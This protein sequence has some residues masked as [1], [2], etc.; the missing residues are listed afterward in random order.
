MA[1]YEY[2]NIPKSCEVGNTIFKKLFYEHADL[3]ISDKNLFIDNINKITWLYCLKPDNINVLPYKDDSRDYPEIEVIEVEI[4][5]D[6]KLKRI[7]EIIM[8]AIPYPMMLIF[9]LDNKIQLYTA[10]QRINQNDQS[11]NTIEEIINTD[12]LDNNS[13]ILKELDIMKMRFANFYYLY[14]DIVDVIS[15]YNASKIISADSVITGEEARILKSEIEAI[16]QKIS[17]L[18]VK[19]KQET[20]FNHKMEFNIQIK[21]LEKQKNKIVGEYAK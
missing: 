15:I 20:Q 2:L 21:N 10:H 6:T 4:S 3:S 14:C 7:S 5:K 18:R 1:L 13:P 12:W 17:N 16:E 11:K 9:K 19:L 8:R